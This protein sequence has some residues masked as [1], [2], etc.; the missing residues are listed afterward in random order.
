MSLTHL[1]HEKVGELIEVYPDY[2][3]TQI[4]AMVFRPEFINVSDEEYLEGL[5][6]LTSSESR[7]DDWMEENSDYVEDMINQ[8]SV[9]LPE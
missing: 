4:L 5:E 2:T 8:R 6:K 3:Y 7:I 9:G 1:C